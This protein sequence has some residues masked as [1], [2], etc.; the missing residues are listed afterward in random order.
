MFIESCIYSEPLYLSF[1]GLCQ[2]PISH[3]IGMPDIFTNPTQTPIIDYYLFILIYA[4][5]IPKIP[6]TRAWI[7]IAF[8]GSPLHNEQ[9]SG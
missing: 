7:H 9:Y 5:L 8:S 4:T 6:S 2:T 3:S 1:K